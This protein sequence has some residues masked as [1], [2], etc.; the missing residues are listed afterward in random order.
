MI[1]DA[2]ASRASTSTASTLHAQ[3]G[4]LLAVGLDSDVTVTG[5]GG[6]RVRARVL[7]V[8]PDVAHAVACP[9]PSL[10]ILYDPEVVPH[11]AAYA[12]RRAGAFAVEGRLGARLGEALL[13]HRASL[14]RADVLDGLAREAAAW[15]A[16]EAEARAPDGRVAR[17]LEALRDPTADPRLAVPPRVSPAHLRA[18][19]ARDVGL[20][21]RTFRLWRRLLTALSALSALARV[22]ATSAAHAAG[23]ADLAHFSRTCRRMLGYS[24]TDLRSR[25]L[26][27]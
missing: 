20:P 9:G 24:P 26:R 22:D 23:F 15:L 8:P 2:F 25:L 10:G 3:H 16:R 1:T 14:G 13:A 7:V 4:A 17:V 6:A 5:P 18:L 27:T 11:V 19:F 12:R 21:I